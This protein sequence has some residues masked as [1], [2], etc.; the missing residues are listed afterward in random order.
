MSS[1][2]YKYN[3]TYNKL[4]KKITDRKQKK[5]LKIISFTANYR[6]DEIRISISKNKK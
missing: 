5:E 2:R 1:L 6:V 3:I 4:K